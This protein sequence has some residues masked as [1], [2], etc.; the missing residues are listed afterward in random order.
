MYIDTTI[1]LYAEHD[2]RK[3]TSLM[4]YNRYMGKK[5]SAKLSSFALKTIQDT[6]NE[7]RFILFFFFKKR[8]V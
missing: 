4:S 7:Y 6:S 2:K 5:R 8:F 1:L 3:W